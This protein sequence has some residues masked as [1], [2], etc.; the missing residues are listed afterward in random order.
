MS[1]LYISHLL[2][3]GE[4]SYG[5]VYRC[6]EKV[7]HSIIALKSVSLEDALKSNITSLGREIDILKECKHPNITLYLGSFIE[8]Q[9]LWIAMEFC[10]GGSC[11]E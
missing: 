2:Q 4:G 11:S 8:A 9:K 3:V 5:S 10:G 6:T 7:S 1:L